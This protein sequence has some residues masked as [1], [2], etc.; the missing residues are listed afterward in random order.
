MFLCFSLWLSLSLMEN[1]IAHG[2]E[3]N[4]HDTLPSPVESRPRLN[5][6][7]HF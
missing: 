4:Q 1:H 6:H 7:Y 3:G 2:P 5:K